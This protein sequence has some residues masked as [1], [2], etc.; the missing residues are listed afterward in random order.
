M[1]KLE[2]PE[3]WVLQA[4]RFCL[5]EERPSPVVSSH[6]GASRFAYNWANRLVED[7]LHARDAYRVLALRQGATVEEAITFSRIMVPV[8]W[9]QAQMRRIWNQEKDF[10]TARDGAEHQAAVEHIR[11]RNIYE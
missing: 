2:V 3:G 6:T 10:V 11:S 4:F 7:Q 9:S 5:D 8:P 1:G